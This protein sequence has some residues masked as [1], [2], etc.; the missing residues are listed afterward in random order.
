MR[1]REGEKKEMPRRAQQGERTI[2]LDELTGVQA[3]ERMHPDLP[4]SQA[5]CCGASSSTSGMAHCPGLSTSMSSPDRS[6]SRLGADT[7]GYIYASM[8]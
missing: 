5:M 2:S 1:K 3:L 8:D 4:C 7:L 6:S